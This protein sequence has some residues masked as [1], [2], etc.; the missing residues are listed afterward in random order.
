MKKGGKGTKGGGGKKGYWLLVNLSLDT[1]NLV[2]YIPQPAKDFYAVGLEICVKFWKAFAY[3]FYRD[4]QSQCAIPHFS[5]TLR[6]AF[7]QHDCRRYDRAKR[8]T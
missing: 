8:P 2:L 5:G 4:G 6:A 1:G 3:G 7:P